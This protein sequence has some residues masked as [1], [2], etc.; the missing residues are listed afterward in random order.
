MSS[1]DRLEAALEYAARGWSVLPCEPHGKRPAGALVSHGLKEASTDLNVIRM[2]WA[3][4]PE[5]NIGL[6]TGIAFDVL[7][8]DGDEGMA[9][10]AVEM[11]ADAPTVDGPTVATGH[12]V[13]CYVAAT[14]LGNRAAFIP[15]C[16]WRGMGGYVIAAGSIHESGAAYSWKCGENDPDFGSSA[17]IRPAPAWLLGLLVRRPAPAPLA[18]AK[19]TNASAY[20]RRA[21]EAECGRI[22]LAPEGQRNHVLN[23]AAFALGQLV[24]GSVL[25][26]GEVVD[27]LLIAAG[28]CGLPEVESRRTIASG[29]QSGAHSPRSIA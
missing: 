3:A 19:P 22:A 9:S 5:A 11:P 7:D 25:D 18:N 28:R 29:L 16:D 6:A 27:A 21:L 10:L 8:V 24:A 26:V 2:W 20:G 17:P 1:Y 23:A 14:G 4:E 15:G 13:H 12:G